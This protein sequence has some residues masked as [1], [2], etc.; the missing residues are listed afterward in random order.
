MRDYVLDF[1][2]LFRGNPYAYVNCAPEVVP[3]SIRAPLT[4]QVWKG[5]LKGNTPIG[6]Y[7]I[8]GQ[9]TVY[10][11][12]V[13]LDLG[14]A[15]SWIHA[16]NLKNVLGTFKIIAWIEKSRSKGY[17][18]WVFVND[19]CP[20]PLMRSALK[21]A[22][23]I[24]GAPDKEVNPKQRLLL[25][26]RQLGN[27]VRAPYPWGWGDGG[28]Q[29]M[30]DLEFSWVATSFAS[31]A[32]RCTNHPD[33]LGPLAALYTPPVRPPIEKRLVTG[34]NGPIGYRERM[35]GLTWTIY[36][37]G[38]LDGAD[39][40]GTMF[41]LACRLRDEGFTTGEAYEIISDYDLRHGKFHERP[42]S[43]QRKEELILK[44]FVVR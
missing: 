35:S 21:A 34:F 11:G 30:I 9:S 8:V 27:C 1:M 39:R 4:Y 25:D 22:C 3:Y 17:H 37:D 38:P 2:D 18:V 44:A 5:H 42:D 36:N 26:P 13:D 15:E 10:W 29:T 7:P 28:P 12:C 14:F 19:G 23:A 24:A 40:S 16:R 20:A 41:K 31:E 33:K 6:V 43:V 32:L